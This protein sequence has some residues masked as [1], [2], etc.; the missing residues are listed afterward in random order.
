MSD[1]NW[2]VDFTRK[3]RCTHLV[4]LCTQRNVVFSSI[5]L[6]EVINHTMQSLVYVLPYH[7]SQEEKRHPVTIFH[8]F[9]DIY[10]KWL[11]SLIDMIVSNSIQ[12][13]GGTQR[14]VGKWALNLASYSSKPSEFQCCSVSQ[15]LQWQWPLSDNQPPLTPDLCCLLKI[16]NIYTIEMILTHLHLQMN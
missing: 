9:I 15:L 6:C 3:T 11:E 2:L 12:D 8:W 14:K 7:G 10:W 5:A 1:V 13:S 4:L 16:D